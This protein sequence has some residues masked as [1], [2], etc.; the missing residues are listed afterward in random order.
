MNIV[1]AVV[2]TRDRP[3]SLLRAVRSLLVSHGGRFELLVIDQSDGVESEQA[4]AAFLS[5]PRLR[6]VRS[7]AHGKGAALNEGL[8]LA[9]GDIVA[10]TDDDCEA[11]PDWAEGL[12]RALEAQPTAAI[13]FC[14]VK[15]APHDRTAGYIPAFERR[16]SRLLRSIGRSPGELGLGAGM[17]VRR[18]AVLA[19]GGFDQ[20]FGP[21]ARFGSGDDWDVAHRALL[22]GWHVYETADLS[23]LHH[24]FR[25]FAEGSEH[26][27]RDWIAIGALCAKP[28]RAGYFSAIVVPVWYFSV[29]ALWPPLHDLL[30]VRRPRGLSR[31]LGFIR[32]FAQGLGTPVDRKTLL[33]RA[34]DWRPAATR[35][36]SD[37]A[38]RL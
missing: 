37:R 13:V 2:C 17:A 23:V 19:L 1:S 25:T 12:G 27:R 28:I 26:A 24:G 6:Y 35:T 4:L 18:A 34:V 7:R 10:F 22:N 30:R 9:H 14:N 11:S 21:G 5:D 38:G 20:A 29:Q 15:A 31:I 36:T 8:R 3:G 16:R 32:G 33:F